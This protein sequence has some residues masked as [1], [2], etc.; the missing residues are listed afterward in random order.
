MPTDPMRPGSPARAS[1]PFRLPFGAGQQAA[2]SGI[3]ADLLFRGSQEILINHNG[4]IYRLRITR[5]GK[6]ILTK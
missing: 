3:P 5:N 6:L 1:A 2:S 4:E